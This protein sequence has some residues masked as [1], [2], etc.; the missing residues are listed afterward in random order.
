VLVAA[1]IWGVARAAFGWIYPE[2]RDIAVLAVQGLDAERQG[3]FD[4]LW[5]EAR[6]GEEKRL[7]ALGAD[8]AQGLAPPCIDWAALSGIAGDHSCSSQAMLETVRTANWILVV[9]DVAAQLKADLAQIPVTAPAE[10]AAATSTALTE[11]QRRLADQASRAQRVNALHTADLRLQRADPQYATRA[12][13]NLAHFLLPRPDT[14]LDPSQYASLALQ[15][16]SVLNAAGVYAWYHISA[17]QKATRLANESLSADARRALARAALFDEAFALHFLEDM[18]S[19][20]HVAGSWGDV[21]QR[22]GTHDFYNEN[23]IE[24]FT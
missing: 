19:A 3:E 4:R 21:S 9:A 24:V 6:A 13:A 22:K 1:L 8:V 7:C 2:H 16:G 10:Q 15:R 5:Q 11:A 17:L 12:D 20:G 18:F 23:G 14:N